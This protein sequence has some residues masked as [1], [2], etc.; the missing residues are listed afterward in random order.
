MS[1]DANVSEAGE[2]TNPTPEA[3]PAGIDRLWALAAEVSMVVVWTVAADLLIFRGRGFFAVAA[4]FAV[5]LVAV[6]VAHLLRWRPAS[7][8]TPTPFW[9]GVG[10]AGTLLLLAVI[11]LG[12]EGSA[13]LTLSAVFALVALVLALSGWLPTLLRLITTT[14]FAPF[15]GAQR[16]PQ[17]QSVSLS[18]RLTPSRSVWLSVLFPVLAVGLFGGIFILANPDLVER[19]S[20][21]LYTTFT[22]VMDFFSEVSLWE[23][24]F[25]VL[26]FFVGMGLLRPLTPG[27][28]DLI[29][30]LLGDASTDEFVTLP[31]PA[32]AG[33]ANSMY[34]PFRNML[35]AL[36]GLFVIYL[37][38][39]FTTLWRREFPAG[40]YYAGYAHQGAAWLTVALALATVTLS[41]IFHDAMFRDPRI[42][43]LRLLAWIWSGTNLLLAVAVYNRL[44]IY[45]GYNGMTRMRTIGFFGITLVL[46]GFALVIVK[47]LRRHSVRWLIQSQLIALSL[48]VVL[49]CLFP[50]D[51]VAHRYNTNRVAG[52]YLKPSVMIAV[53]PIDD[54]GIF[55]LFDLVDH[56]DETIREGVR[57]MLANRQREIESYA[58]DT[59]WSWHRYQY[60]KTLLYRKLAAKQS[61]WTRY[62]RDPAAGE[63]AIKRF[64]DYAMQWY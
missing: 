35:V 50:V 6:A 4:F 59:P 9:S 17:L 13:E 63:L 16:L 19:V 36:I 3:V 37:A 40:F 46:V 21:S 58:R 14:M 41:M 42:E 25:C 38:F 22:R 18:A 15:L 55:P 52:G 32:D 49:Y 24:P 64:E 8:L 56:S 26:A 48:A 23:L 34:A 62:V 43:R 29:Q 57:A 44:S 10:V 20:N 60:A 47:I 45:V 1:H 33:E 5:A 54:E 2:F 39:E 61:K 7:E 30:R 31:Q 51:Y 11:R 28:G 53:K 12:W 27:Q